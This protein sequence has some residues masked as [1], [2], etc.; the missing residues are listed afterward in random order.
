MVQGIGGITERV[1]YPMHDRFSHA[2]FSKGVHHL[3]GW[4]A[5]AFARDRHDVPGGDISRSKDQGILLMAA[6][7]KLHDSFRQ[8]P[9]VVF[10]WVAVGWRNVRTNLSFGTLVELGLTASQIPPSNVNNFV[11][12]VSFGR[13]GAAAVVFIRPNARSLYADMRN[14]GVIGH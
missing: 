6:L 11:V 3:Q 5:L 14:N 4:Q 12:P 7:A 2:N 8:N 9:S 10:R 1:P 13:E